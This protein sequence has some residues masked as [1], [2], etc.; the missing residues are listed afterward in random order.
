MTNKDLQSIL[1]KFPDDLKI[2]SPADGCDK[3]DCTECTSYG[4]NVCE[5]L[6]G[7]EGIHTGTT[8]AVSGRIGEK[9]LI[10]DSSN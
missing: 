2:Y 3:D 8:S 10:L 4:R 1:M 5:Y 9:V 7:V 6:C